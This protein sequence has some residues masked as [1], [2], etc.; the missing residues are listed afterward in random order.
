MS[1]H[2]GTFAARYAM[3]AD[4]Y[5]RVKQARLMDMEL[6]RFRIG[7]E[8]HLDPAGAEE[9]AVVDTANREKAFFEWPG[10]A[11]VMRVHAMVEGHFGVS[12]YRVG[13]RLWFV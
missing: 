10:K 2:R 3:G 11:D 9:F 8:G 5:Q 13:A 6:R 7:E 12:A 1:Q 4:R